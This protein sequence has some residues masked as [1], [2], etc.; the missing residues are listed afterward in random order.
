MDPYTTAAVVKGGS[1]IFGQI[2]SWIGGSGELD[3]L[4]KNYNRSRSMLTSD[5]GKDIFDPEQLLALSDVAQ[6]PKMRATGSQIARQSGNITAADAQGALWER[7]LAPRQEM[8]T[9][10]LIANKQGMSDR[11]AAIKRLL[12]QGDAA[13]LA[14]Y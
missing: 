5:I 1:D 13:A 11:D 12:F 4:K 3:R 6:I 7:L 14:G 2:A 10:S 9:Q 8:Y